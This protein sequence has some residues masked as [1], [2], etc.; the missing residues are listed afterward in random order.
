MQKRQI[1]NEKRKMNA[2]VLI[3]FSVDKQR[4]QTE[5]KQ[6]NSMPNIQLLNQKN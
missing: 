2:D 1:F 5:N 3:V 4:K 6:D